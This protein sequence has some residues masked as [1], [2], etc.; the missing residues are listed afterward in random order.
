MLHTEIF[1]M[2]GNTYTTD[3]DTLNVLRSLVPAAK[4]SGDSSAVIAVI[5]LGE[6]T[7]R[8]RKVEVH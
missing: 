4:L 8:I 6:N 3:A 7:G 5:A 1:E 2:N